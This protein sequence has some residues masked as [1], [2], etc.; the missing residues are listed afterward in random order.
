MSKSPHSVA[1]RTL[2]REGD[3]EGSSPSVGNDYISQEETD[4][5][6]ALQRKYHSLGVSTLRNIATHYFLTNQTGR[7]LSLWLNVEKQRFSLCEG[8][9]KLYPTFQENVQNISDID[10]I[11]AAMAIMPEPVDIRMNGWTNVLIRRDGSITTYLK[12][13]TNI[14]DPL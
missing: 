4:R 1:E 13:S 11:G 9:G 3:S 8:D 12:A 14:E 5:I 6:I 2:P 10:Q 7:Y